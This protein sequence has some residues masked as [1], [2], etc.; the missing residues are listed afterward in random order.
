MELNRL[1]FGGL[2]VGC[3]AAAA[4]GG[5]LAARQAPVEAEAAVTR[6]AEPMDEP[7]VTAAVAESEGVIPAAALDAP[8]SATLSP[9]TSAEVSTATPVVEPATTRAPAAVRRARSSSSSPSRSPRSADP[10][11]ATAR[12]ESSVN[13]ASSASSGPSAGGMWE[14]RPSVSP[15]RAPVDVVDPDPVPAV[16]ELVDLTIPADAVLGLRLDRSISSENAR[17]E[18]RVE[19]RVA[20]DVR[21]GNKVAIPAGSTVHG[22]VTEVDRGGKVRDRARLG[23]RFHT[24][25]LA[26]GGRLNIKTDAVV[27]EGEAPAKESAAKIGG[28]AVGGAILGAILGGKKGAIIGGATGA[29]GGT[30]VTMAGGRNPA[31]LASGTTLSVR[32]QQPVTV[33][34]ER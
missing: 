25:A 8:V 12:T 34:V 9:A 20:R 33:S 21:V 11:P 10:T 31:V 22:S 24:I 29:A 15:E 2:A 6:A 30:A 26:G 1:V 23:I 14:T 3:M 7:V 28:A 5:Y 17:V 19:A 4:G 18:D 13:S 16:A 32:I 27:R